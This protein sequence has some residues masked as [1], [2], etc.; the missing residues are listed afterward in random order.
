MFAFTRRRCAFLA[1]ILL[2]AGS[3]GVFS[4][5][6]G[7]TYGRAAGTREARELEDSWWEFS[8]REAAVARWEEVHRG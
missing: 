7:W 1:I 6:V 5:S 2:F 8:G 4:L 3:T